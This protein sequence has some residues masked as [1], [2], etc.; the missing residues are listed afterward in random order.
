VK[1]LLGDA[2]KLDS[3]QGRYDFGLFSHIPRNKIDDFLSG[4]HKKLQPG[5]KVFMAD[6]VYVP[7]RGGE[8]MT[9]ED[10][11]DTYKLR[12]LDDGTQYEIIKNKLLQLS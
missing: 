8:L 2:Y 10:S 1:F 5:S 7:G 11:E 9:K 6:N 4:F 3:V 12:Q